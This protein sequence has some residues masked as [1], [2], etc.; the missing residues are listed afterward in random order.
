MEEKNVG[1]VFP[2]SDDTLPSLSKEDALKIKK[3]L[4]PQADVGV[5]VGRFQ[6][7]ELHE[8]HISLIKSIVESHP[9]VIVFLGLSPCKCTTRNPLDF[10]ARK[11]MITD[12][13]PNVIVLYIMDQYS[14]VAWS[15]SLDNQIKNIAGP[16]QSVVLYGSRDSFIKYYSGK[17]ACAELEQTVFVSGTEIRKKISNSVSGTPEFRKGVIW[18]VNNQYPKCFPTVDVAI[19]GK[20]QGK[21]S[22]LL[23]KRKVEPKYRFVGGF[24]APG[25]TLEDAAFR[26]A[27][28]ETCLALRNIRYLKS[29]VCDDWRYRNELDK[30]TTSLFTG[31]YNGGTPQPNDDIDQ[32]RWFFLDSSFNSVIVDEHKEMIEYLQVVME[33]KI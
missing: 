4:T 29:F 3:H 16:Q 6:V 10:E 23:G 30:I 25:E 27:K 9:K 2:Y 5:I 26:E 24:V 32:L 13:F 22:V 7:D 31:E 14:D 12:A 15:D 18:A 8:G 17:Y 11:K 28:E 33:S 19:L 21:L 20:V 1:G